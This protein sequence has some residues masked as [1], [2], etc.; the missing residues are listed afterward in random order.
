MCGASGGKR[1]SPV[2]ELRDALDKLSRLMD[3]A[4]DLKH[5]AD[6]IVLGVASVKAQIRKL[7][8]ESGEVGP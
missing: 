1:P 3:E 2:A 7:T 8:L 5:A 6:R 4:R